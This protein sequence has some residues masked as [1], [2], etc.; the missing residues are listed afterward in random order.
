VEAPLAPIPVPQPVPTSGPDPESVEGV[1]LRS[2]RDILAGAAEHSLKAVE[3]A[4]TLRARGTTPLSSTVPGR[5]CFLVLQRSSFCDFFCSGHGGA[6]THPREVGRI[7]VPSGEARDH[8][9]GRPHPQERQG[10]P[11]PGPGR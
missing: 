8:F 5:H 10:D 9:Q 7:A 11:D 3:L 1:V 2:C 4:N 6:R